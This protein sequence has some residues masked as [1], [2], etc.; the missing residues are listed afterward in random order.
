MFRGY[1]VT[2]LLKITIDNIEK[3]GEIVDTAVDNGANTVRN[4]NMTV[5]NQEHFYQQALVNAIKNA[6][7]K[8]ALVADTLGVSIE[9]IPSH[10]KEISST[11]PEQ[12]RA[13]VLGVSTEKAAT[14]LIE[15]GQ[16]KITALVE[17]NF[18]Y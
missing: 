6:Q 16:F 3:V 8:A 18:Q 17:A 12:P 15:A 7:E 14:T 1:Q 4:I 13:F 11:S 5:S 9:E 2:N 10:L